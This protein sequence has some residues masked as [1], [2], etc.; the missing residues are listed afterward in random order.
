MNLPPFKLE[1]YF[2]QYEFKVRYLLSPSD[3]EAFPVKDLLA[4]AS[5][6]D[7]RAWEQLS[8]GY[9]ESSGDPLLRQAVTAL[10][11]SINID[12]V[13]IAAPEELI[14]LA[15]YALLE[16]GDGVVAISPAYQSLYEL[17]GA[18]GCRVT[19]WPLQAQG[20][21]WQVDLDRLE[22]SLDEHT[23]MIVINFPHNPTGHLLDL[24]QQTAIIAMARK[25][26]IYVFSD[27]MYRLLEH[28]PA[29]RLPALCDRYERAVTLSGLS[30]T[31]AMP[32]LRIGWLASR[33]Q[34]LIRRCQ[35]F[36]DYTTICNSAPS[37]VLARI[38]LGAWQTVAE[39]SLG[40]VQANL[41][42]AR[43]FFMARPQHFEWLQPLAG[44]TAFPRYLGPGTV[45]DFCRQALDEQGVMI[46]PGSMFDFP[47]GH[48]RIGLGRANFR[49][50]LEKVG[51][52]NGLD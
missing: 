13:L 44:S 1:R 17:A 15:M 26:G 10:Y 22:A 41:A 28:D 43:Q 2:A 33:D 5:A 40:I 38:A 31:F 19:P 11:T 35:S 39:R 21:A 51:S 3:C 4:L 12:D 52:L 34:D 46:V 23:R 49:E 27:E 48:F 45:D 7:L 29:R 32:G 25:R 16:P 47:G 18:I 9:T 37:E 30:K 24:D 6:D 14:F 36:K 50:A 8:L 42:A 20:G